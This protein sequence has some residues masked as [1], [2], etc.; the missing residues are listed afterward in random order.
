MKSE[1]SAFSSFGQEVSAAWSIFLAQLICA[2][3]PPLLVLKSFGKS[4]LFPCNPWY[5]A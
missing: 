3:F 2:N 1:F 5:F 4:Q